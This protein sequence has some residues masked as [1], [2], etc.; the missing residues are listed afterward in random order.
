VLLD[1][2]LHADDFY[3]DRHRTIYEAIIRLNEDANPVDVLTVSEQLEQ[4]GQLEAIGGRD[5]IASLAAK[6][7]SPGSAKHYAQIVKQNS[8]MRRLD[9]AAKRIQQSVAERD[10]EPSEM[11]E[12]AERL[13]FQVAH[14]ERAVDFREIG[15]ILHD[16]IDKLEALAS[17]TSDIT[18]T[19]SGFRDLDDKTGGFQPGNLIVIAA[20]PAMG[21]CQPGRTLVYDAKT[22][23][24]CR[25][26][27][28]VA[29]HESGEEIWV[30]A[31]GPDL[32]LRPARI[33]HSI[34]S[35]KQVVHR[36]TTRLGR[37]VEA[38]ANHPLLTFNGWRPLEELS[39][40]SRIGVPRWLPRMAPGGH[41]EDHEIVLLAALIA[42]GSIIR[43]T[44]MYCFGADGT[45]LVETVRAAAA[46]AGARFN[47][48]PEGRYAYLSSARRGETNPVTTLCRGHG[49]Y[50]KRS[51]DKFVPD[52]IF[53][54]PDHQIARFLAVLFGCDG[55]VHCTERL[56]HVGYTTISERLARDVQHLLLRLGIVSCI[57]TLKRKV[58]EGTDKVAREV[59]ITDQRS[60]A[61]FAMSVRIVG[62]EE[63]LSA[64]SER[65]VTATPETNV[66]TAPVEV[67]DK[68]LAA[69]ADRSWGDVSEAAGYPRNHDWHVGK[70]GLSRR[71]LLQMAD[72][73]EAPELEELADSD[74]WWD[75]VASIE[76]IGEEETY[77]LTVPD[78]H[79]FVADDVIV[80]NS[81]L[82]CDFAQNV[83][84]KHQKPVALFSLEMSEMELA[85]RFIGSQSRISSDRL[86][87]GKVASKDWPK[88]VK[89]CNQL[90][91]APL[92]IDDSSDLGLLELRA[93]ARRLHAQEK[94]RGHD[95]LGMVIV[96]YMQLM[97]SD[98]S[99][100]NRVEQ[101]S[102]F[103]RGLK[104]LARELAVPV[105]GISQLS[106]APEQRPDKRPILSDLRESGAIEQ[107]ADVV[108][109]LYRDDYYNAD[110]EDP[111]GAELILAKHRNGP[112][113]T[114]RL[115][116]LE[117][118]PKFA[119]RAR[120]ERPLEQPA[121]EGPPIE[122]IGSE[123]DQFADAEEG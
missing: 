60:L 20:R 40:G 73:L 113:G 51:E 12:Q 29:R 76:E 111:G 39:V 19:P 4:H 71:R 67:W 43:G 81:T 25:L 108:G 87:K 84:M 44:P 80:H 93:K 118:Y 94:G 17:G 70:R 72:V 24:R 88:V 5:V 105:I 92:W 119:D 35:G 116:F 52:A 122:D 89:A 32:K 101:V 90:E 98:D 109:F 21:K 14:E 99:R 48:G 33:S 74:I 62:K 46:N 45:D 110:S 1:A 11:V 96:D 30:G 106:R 83:A 22:G 16:E 54:L 57:R 120:E 27:E 7:P 63:K 50:G 103:S 38:T 13:L 79:N 104:I 10:G 85:H 37:T 78:H 102:Q 23:A 65:L 34:R 2:R 75:E 77:D 66:D 112:V 100:A 86:R 6:V 115:V 15:E 47:V 28:L 36:L 121:G 53:E 91:S 61:R 123:A 68:V 3:R 9:L 117:H 114:V 82:V 97:R 107:D 8:L 59:R 18:G 42:D 64:V 69:K 31:M 95:G 41:M 49:L 58:Y 26:D 56:A 55:Y